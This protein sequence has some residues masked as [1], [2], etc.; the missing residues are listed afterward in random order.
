MTMT[1]NYNY[2]LCLFTVHYSLIT[3]HH[4]LKTSYIK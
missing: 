2:E 3:N 1:M 4:C